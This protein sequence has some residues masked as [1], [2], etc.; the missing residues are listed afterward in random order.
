MPS[1]FHR[2]LAHLDPDPARA[3]DRFDQLRR[4]LVRFFDWR[5]ATSPEDGADETIHRLAGRLEAGL[6]VLDIE[7]FAYGIARLVQHELRRSTL[8]LAS[9][10]GEVPAVAAPEPSQ[11]EA[12]S[13]HLQ[14]CLDALP[15]ESRE[16][17]LAY[18][19]GGEGERKIEARRR[20]ANRLGLTPSTLRSRV[21]R[22]R[23]GL[24]DDLRLL[25]ER[26]TPA[27]SQVARGT[28]KN[29]RRAS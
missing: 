2:L 27:P 24:E 8:R 21:Q 29:I 25:W 22:L 3:G 13:A 5:G 23:E 26:S 20:L 17:L 9:L 14:Q 11:A 4:K 15:R 19:S 18:Y 28:W 12:L 10:D 16:L 7:A 6:A 1:G